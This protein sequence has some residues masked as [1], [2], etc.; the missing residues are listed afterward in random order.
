MVLYL[1]VTIPLF[2]V[3]ECRR[4]L[5]EISGFVTSFLLRDALFVLP[6]NQ[7]DFIHQVKIS[8]PGSESCGTHL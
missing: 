1:F 4:E 6:S 2:L 3:R 5:W 7:C 8:R